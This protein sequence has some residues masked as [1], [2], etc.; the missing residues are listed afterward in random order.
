MVAVGFRV[1]PEK[2]INTPSGIQIV[3]KGQVFLDPALPAVKSPTLGTFKVQFAGLESHATPRGA[4]GVFAP[5]LFCSSPLL[6]PFPSGV[7]SRCAR[8]RRVA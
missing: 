1:R 3:P 8:S 5:T 6:R 2:P 7:E 4:D